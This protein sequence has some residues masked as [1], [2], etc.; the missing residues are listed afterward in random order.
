MDGGCGR[1]PRLA[2]QRSTAAEFP[3]AT[4]SLCNRIGLAVYPLRVIT[5][6]RRTASSCAP[7]A[8][9][10]GSK[11]CLVVLGLAGLVRPLGGR[12]PNWE[13]A[14]GWRVRRESLSADMDEYNIPLSSCLPRCATERD[15][16][17]RASR[18]LPRSAPP[19]APARHERSPGTLARQLSRDM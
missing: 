9:L 12:R 7:S 14:E 16:P 8:S 3:C 1:A 6:L 18:T 5:G 13:G 19:R 17:N 4:A 2:E 11:R 10:R 15:A